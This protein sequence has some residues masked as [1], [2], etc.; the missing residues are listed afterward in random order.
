MIILENEIL[1]VALH[2][3]GAEI[4]SIYNK[5]LALEYLWNGDERFWPRRS[6]V[7]FPIVGGLKDDSYFY[8]STQYSLIKHGF[9]RDMEFTPKFNSAE[10][11]S[12][13]LK[14]TAETEASYPFKFELTIS[15]YLDNNKL[16][17]EYEVLNTSTEVMFFSIG[18]HPA[19]N[20]P[21]TADGNY[22]DYYL[23]FSESET[24][25]RHTLSGNLI[26]DAIP[27][28]DNQ[29]KIPLTH[30]LFED[31]ALV[32]KNLKSKHVDLKSSKHDVALRFNFHGFP[33]MG[34]WAAKNAPF[35]CIEPWYGIADSEG[36]NQNIEEKEGIIS[37][38]ENGEWKRSWSVEVVKDDSV[39]VI[40]KR[41]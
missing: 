6:P 25:D 26:S 24:A 34:I 29:K 27:F 15:Y 19:F 38:P 2:P 32:F 41:L 21:L 36:H 16:S 30:E 12:F 39:R 5:E 22:E 10:R 20:V 3:F 13:V 37:L 14:S 35:V 18:A 1:R 17:V 40:M 23:E 11:A 33:Y 9:A 8:N 4:H 28:F 7:L 31:D